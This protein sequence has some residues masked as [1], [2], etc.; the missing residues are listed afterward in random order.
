MKKQK[1][2]FPAAIS[3]SQKHFV[4]LVRFRYYTAFA[5]AYAA[6]CRSAAGMKSRIKSAVSL[7][8]VLI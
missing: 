4:F 1:I 2:L 7:E 5:A 6:V 3:G 8:I